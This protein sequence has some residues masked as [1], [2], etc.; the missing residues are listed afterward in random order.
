MDIGKINKLA[1]EIMGKRKAHLERETGFIYNHGIR[2]AALSLNLYSELKNNDEELKD[3]L[4]TGALFHDIGKGIGEHG[5]TGAV[6]VKDI[7]KNSCT[8]EEI[9]IISEIVKMH[10]KRGVS[11]LP[12]IVKV[13]Q[14]ADIL[15]HRGSLE[16]W[17]SFMYSSYEDKGPEYASD[18]WREDFFKQQITKVRDLLNFDISKKIF[19]DRVD[20]EM[21]FIERFIVESN[22]G[23]FKNEWCGS[24]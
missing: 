3:V 10:N 4:Y 12:D 13:V 16:M 17:I 6:L 8:Y 9:D 5:A 21:K 23:I 2:V 11:H 22:G 14:D 19:D 15:D 18:F 24:I 7:L 20:F 1:L